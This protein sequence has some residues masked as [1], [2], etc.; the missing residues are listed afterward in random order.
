MVVEIFRDDTKRTR[1]ITV[2]KPDV[3]LELMEECI[4]IFKEKIPWDFIE[5]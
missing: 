5:Y 2:F 3:S 4:A 1:T